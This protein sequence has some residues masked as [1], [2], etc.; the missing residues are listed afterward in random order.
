MVTTE[1]RIA[2]HFLSLG[3][4]TFWIGHRWTVCGHL[5]KKVAAHMQ[6]VSSTYFSHLLFCIDFRWIFW[7]FRSSSSSSSLFYYSLFLY[8]NCLLFSFT[9]V[10][11]E[12]EETSTSEILLQVLWYASCN[13]PLS[14]QGQWATCAIDISV[15]TKHNASQCVKWATPLW[16]NFG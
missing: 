3:Y 1:E 4:P 14:S 11:W 12:W 8:G 5:I 7:R 15:P 10:V 9:I 6:L 13:H 2:N 16:S